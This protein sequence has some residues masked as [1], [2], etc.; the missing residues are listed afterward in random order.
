MAGTVIRVLYL[1]PKMPQPHSAQLSGGSSKM[2]HHRSLA[3]CHRDYDERRAHRPAGKIHSFEGPS[4]S[5]RR[6]EAAS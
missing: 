1:T 4:G 2:K 6:C 5:I 3:F